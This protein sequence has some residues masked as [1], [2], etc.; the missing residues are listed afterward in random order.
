M[1]SSRSISIPV[2]NRSILNTSQLRPFS[3]CVHFSVDLYLDCALFPFVSFINQCF[4][5]DPSLIPVSKRPVKHTRQFRPFDQ[6]TNNTVDLNI[7]CLLFISLLFAD[8][9]PS[10][11]CW[12]IVAVRIDS[13]NAQPLC[14][15]VRQCPFAE[16]RKVFPFVAV[17]DSS[18]T[19]PCKRLVVGI[20]A[21]LFHLT[22]H[23]A[24][25]VVHSLLHPAIHRTI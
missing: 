7:N 8:G 22:P 14:V 20:V 19:I 16:R 25:L 15:S 2:L 3:E 6:S 12:L 24:Q 10:A 4:T 9:D 17:R 13:V 5:S 23:I 18:A 1:F 11:V 21:S